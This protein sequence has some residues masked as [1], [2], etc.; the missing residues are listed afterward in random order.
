MTKAKTNGQLP[1]PPTE[2]VALLNRAWRATGAVTLE[3]GEDGLLGPFAPAWQAIATLAPEDRP[4]RAYDAWIKAGLQPQDIARITGLTA[5]PQ[6]AARPPDDPLTK[7]NRTDAG[8]AE[9]LAH[10]HGQDLR[11]CHTA[12]AWHVW[13]GAVWAVDRTGE[14]ERRMLDT[15]RARYHA[16]P[17]VADLEARGRLAAWAIQS[18]SAAKIAAGMRSAQPLAALA[19]TVEQFDQHPMRLATQNATIDLATGEVYAPRREDLIT[20]CAGTRYDAGAKC[21]RW[22]RHLAEVFAGD[23]DLIAFFR[24]AVGY[25]LTGDTREQVLFLLHGPGANGKSVTLSTLAKLLGDYAGSTPFETF[26]SDTGE[27]RHDLA[28]LRGARL[29]T[30]IETNEDRRLNEARVKSLTGGDTVTAEAKYCDPFDYRPTYKVWLAL[31]HL[32][33]VRGTDR[34][35]WRRILLLPFTQSFEGREDRT[36][37][38]TLEAE[39]PGILNWA[40]QGAREWRAEGLNPPARVKAETEQY[41][42]DSDLVGQ[43]IEACT[44]Q[45]P[46]GEMDASAGY[47]SFA[48]WATDNGYRPE[49]QNAWARRM[50]ERGIERRQRGR[51]RFYVG[52][53][54]IEAKIAPPAEQVEL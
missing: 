16:A 31:N 53:G 49:A 47:Q 4:G 27:A 48:A 26:D 35:I 8:N 52:L 29:V 20:K 42:R 45:G 14:A 3:P 39:L 43:W 2:V 44:V 9:C 41:R 11:Y 21:P 46:A 5:T 13:N 51:K 1:S 37:D 24:R 23:A 30:V 40:I 54:L 6:S 19:V 10:R 32:P 34:A 25:S 7:A 50:T 15:V 22:D 33:T 12:R 36:L 28:K 38:K 17:Q 18:E